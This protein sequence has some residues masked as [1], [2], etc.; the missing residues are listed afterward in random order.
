MHETTTGITGNGN[1]V[2]LDDILDAMRKLSALPNNDQWIVV[3]PQGRMYKGKVEEVLP[4][5]TAA[6]PLFK[7]P[8][9]FGPLWPPCDV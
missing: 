5:L 3:D 4:V 7:T 2:K 1:P 6:H 8:I 9:S